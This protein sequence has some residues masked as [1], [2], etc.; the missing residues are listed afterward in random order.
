MP[1]CTVATP[2]ATAPKRLLVIEDDPMIVACLRVRLRAGG[3]DCVAVGDGLGG[4][5]EA[6]TNPPSVVLLDI[7]LP[8]MDGFEVCRELRADPETAD[9]PVIVLSANVTDDVR[10]ASF[11]AGARHVVAKPYD[12]RRLTALVDSCVEPDDNPLN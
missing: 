5:A 12:A 2:C 11:E 7:R 8:G 10:A 4:L 3:Y 9:V 1:C 6:R